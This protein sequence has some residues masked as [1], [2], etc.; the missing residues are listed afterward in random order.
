MKTLIAGF[1]LMMAGAAVAQTPLVE[2]SLTGIGI[3]G[4]TACVGAGFNADN[5]IY[6]ACHTVTS[7]PCSGRGCQPVTTTTNY[8]ATWDAVGNPLGTLACN[9]VR[10]HLPQADIVTPLNGIDPASCHGVVFNTTT[11]TVEIGGTPY[12]WVT[13]DTATGAELVNSSTAGFLYQP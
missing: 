9:T 6:G 11:G 10:H 2:P 12:Y 5:S 8:I 13:T 1:L 3:A 7:P 4:R